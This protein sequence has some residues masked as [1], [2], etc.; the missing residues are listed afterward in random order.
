MFV[1]RRASGFV[2]VAKYYRNWICR[3]G[4]HYGVYG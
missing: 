3:V 4:S 2:Q 1:G